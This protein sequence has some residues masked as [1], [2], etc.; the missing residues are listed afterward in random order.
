MITASPIIKNT[1]M[2]FSE[3]I[4]NMRFIASTKYVH[5]DQSTVT[6]TADDWDMMTSYE[7]F[8]PGI[9]VTYDDED[10]YANVGG[11]NE[12][13]EAYYGGY[14]CVTIYADGQR[15]YDNVSFD[16]EIIRN[17]MVVSKIAPNKLIAKQAQFGLVGITNPDVLKNAGMFDVAFNITV[18][19]YTQIILHDKNVC[20]CTE[21]G[22]YVMEPLT[23]R[24]MLLLRQ[25]HQFGYRKFTGF[26]DVDV[27][28]VE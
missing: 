5:I 24:E 13:L 28:T 4:P 7:V 11:Y 3:I 19:E 2:S 16:D 18:G 27:M 20:L 23:D 6:I 22:W 1:I 17:S 15:S 25:S 9:V 10:Q 8:L 26:S 21:Y 12:K 14:D